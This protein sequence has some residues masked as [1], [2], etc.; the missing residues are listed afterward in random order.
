MTFSLSGQSEKNCLPPQHENS[1]QETNLICKNQRKNLLATRTKEANVNCEQPDA[2]KRQKPKNPNPPSIPCSQ[3]AAH[4]LEISSQLGGGGRGAGGRQEKA[5]HSQP[6]IYCRQSNR[7]LGSQDRYSSLSHLPP[8]SLSLGLH[9]T[10]LPKQP[11]EAA[12]PQIPREQARKLRNPL[13]S[14]GP[15]HWVGALPQSPGFKTS[16]WQSCT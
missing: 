6:F 13:R 9:H 16:T 14:L 5:A 7:P 1:Q 8:L 3:R 4:S 11:S 2:Y 15:G 12:T 10:P